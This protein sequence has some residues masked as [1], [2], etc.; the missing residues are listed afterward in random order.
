MSD[1]APGRAPRVAIAF[2][3][4]AFAAVATGCVK[5][6]TMATQ[7]YSG[8][9]EGACRHYVVCKSEDDGRIYR[10]CVR[11]CRII[12]A[13]DGVEDQGTLG[14]LERLDCEEVL[15]FIEGD[16]GVEPGSGDGSAESSAAARDRRHT[17]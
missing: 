15:G 2:I 12:F 6:Q 9:C 1:M 17:D 3:L 14:E 4:L 11:E 10:A 8:S 5:K 7:S 16:A 13:E